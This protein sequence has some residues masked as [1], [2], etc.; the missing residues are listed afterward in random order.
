MNQHSRHT[1]LVT[2]TMVFVVFFA[3]FGV[4]LTQAQPTPKVAK[5]APHKQV[6]LLKKTKPKLLKMSAAT[7]FKSVTDGLPHALAK[8][9]EDVR[10]QIQAIQKIQ[11]QLFWMNW[12]YGEEVYIAPTYV[13]REK[14]ISR[15]TLHKLTQAIKLAKNPR[16]KKALKHLRSYVAEEII[17]RVITP[18]QQ[19]VRN[20]ETSAIIIV[21]GKS[22][23]YRQYRGLLGKEPDPQKR[24]A[25]LNACLP[26]LKKMNP[27]LCQKEAKTRKL[28]REL[29]FGS[30]IAFSEAFR[31][32]KIAPL[33]QA[34]EKFLKTT[35]DINR[36]TLARLTRSHLG[37]PLK[38]F[39][40]SD[41]LRF[42]K[43]A[44]FEKYFPL[45]RNLLTTQMT[46]TN[47]GI[48]PSGQQHIKIHSE[49]LP[50]KNP[51]AISIPV[52]IP[53]D[54]R[55]SIKPM[56]GWNDLHALFHE[57]GSALHY[58]NTKTNIFEFQQLGSKTVNETYAFLFSSLM[59]NR[60]WVEKYTSLRG[61]ELWDY[62]EFM[63]FKKLYMVRRY[64]AKLLFEYDWHRG[65]PN[66][67]E[68]YRKY[69]SRAY[70]FP[71]TKID[72]MR[73][74]N[75]HD[76]YFYSAEY[77]RAWF[78]EAQLSA[79]LVKHFGKR[80]FL[81]P[82]AGAFLKSLWAKGQEMTG[83]ELSRKLGY[84]GIESKALMR[85]LRNLLDP[86]SVQ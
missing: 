56:G 57:W 39:G 41:I 22:Y 68:R 28:A 4:P 74:L 83:E 46:L 20:I 36:R 10:Q 66:P 19:K 72:S 18:L 76:D 12:V 7:T 64:A 77:L 17:R 81:N 49:P 52:S 2:F 45:N 13:G 82:K 11:N 23:P 6:K 9:V 51:R 29:G 16:Q 58:A 33:A 67:A 30:Y 73:F 69:L 21:N 1:R 79:Y 34:A 48:H 37:I 65:Y 38:K 84:K 59:E 75:D 71:L 32:F 70:G 26:V 5:K 3:W 47:M 54:I 14:V 40:R 24:R 86:G 50:K 78:L 15:K 85:R 27:L 25:I 55:L 63:A 53:D 43:L 42:F 62:L 35:D 61:K 8:L 44:Q 31:G 60:Y 80:W